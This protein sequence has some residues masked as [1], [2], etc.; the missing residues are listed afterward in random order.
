[1][2][3]VTKAS[4]AKHRVTET[5]SRHK[6]YSRYADG[7]KPSTRIWTLPADDATPYY[8]AF[9]RKDNPRVSERESY[10]IAEGVIGFSR[11]YGV[12]A[13]LI[14]AMV[15]CESDFNPNERSNKGAMGLGQ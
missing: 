13:R 5:S 14:M 9:V 1:M 8:A 6:G 10:R 4:T 2:A 7:I 3:A 15:C 12:D 11:K